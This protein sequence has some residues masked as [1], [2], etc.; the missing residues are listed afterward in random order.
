[1]TII[2]AAAP[3]SGRILVATAIDLRIM[4][5]RLRSLR[6]HPNERDPKQCDPV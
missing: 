5:K 1:L 2:V 6:N 3:L 4:S